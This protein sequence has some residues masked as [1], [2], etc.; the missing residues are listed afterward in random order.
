MSLVT[1]TIFSIFFSGSQS[2]LLKLFFVKNFISKYL[3][4]PLAQ[5]VRNAVSSFSILPLFAK[6]AKL[7]FDA[8]LLKEGSDSG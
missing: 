8:N 6:N 1:F 7:Y 5:L 3:K 4:F 2:A